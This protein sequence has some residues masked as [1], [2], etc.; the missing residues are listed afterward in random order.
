MID[1]ADHTV[2]V[3]EINTIPGSF[4]FY[5]FEPVG[6]PYPQLIDRLV[7]Y[8]YAAH[9]EKKGS[10]FAYDSELLQ[11]AVLGGT[12]GAKGTKLN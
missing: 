4:A 2:Y 11:K 10:V 3:N 5:L 1:E 12:K 8:A 9:K 7:E 6:V